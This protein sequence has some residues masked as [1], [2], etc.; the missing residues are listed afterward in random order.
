MAFELW[1][2]STES[3]ART[4]LR[5]LIHDLRGVLP[6][7]DQVI[8]TTNRT[9][10]WRPS[11]P[12]HVDGT[13]SSTTYIQRLNT[14]GGLAPTSRCDAVHVGASAPV[15]YTADYYFYRPA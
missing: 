6:D 13:F 12:A 4:N 5:H 9:L 1:P 10:Q 11:V 3:Q 2:D 15:S 8:Q 14:T 7:M